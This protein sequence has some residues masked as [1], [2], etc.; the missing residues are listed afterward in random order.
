[1]HGSLLLENAR[2]PEA[3]RLDAPEWAV[4]LGN[5][6]VQARRRARLT[7]KALAEAA[8]ISQVWLSKIERGLVSKYPFDTLAKLEPQVGELGAGAHRD[9]PAAR[10][11]PVFRCGFRGDPRDS[12]SGPA[13]DHEEYAPVGH[14]SLIG[15]NGFAVLIRGE[16]LAPRDIHDGDI[17]WINPDRPYG[18]GRTVLARV[19]DAS[20]AETGTVIKTVC[21]SQ[22]GATVVLWDGPGTPL[23]DRFEVIGPVVGISPAFRLPG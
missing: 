20:G 19:W 21:R 13:P 2:E 9:D 7:Q 14:E 11:V 8:G 10:R 12:D 3:P 23:V 5:R 15:P 18:S 16:R 6:V 17:V 1:M 4:D 22:Q